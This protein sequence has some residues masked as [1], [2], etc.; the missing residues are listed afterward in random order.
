MSPSPRPLR[1]L[2]VGAALLVLA[3]CTSGAEGPSAAPEPVE[4]S[5]TAVT[6]EGATGTLELTGD[7]EVD[8]AAL[9][10]ES[11]NREWASEQAC[12]PPEE[13]GTLMELWRAGLTEQRHENS[14]WHAVEDAVRITVHYDYPEHYDA[15][16]AA[17][18]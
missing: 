18:G 17:L 5:A 8:I 1:W 14:D 4:T 13:E 16:D 9:D 10:L 3:G 7:A 12:G 2:A 11:F 6:L 15:V